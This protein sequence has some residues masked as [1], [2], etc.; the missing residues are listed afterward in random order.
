MLFRSDFEKLLSTTGSNIEKA[1]GVLYGDGATETAT[2]V[3]DALGYDDAKGGASIKGMRGC[4]VFHSVSGNNIFFPIGKSG[5][6]R[7]KSGRGK[8]DAVG[9]EGSGEANMDGVL[10]YAQRHA[11]FKERKE[12]TLA[13]GKDYNGGVEYMP[14]F[15]DLFKRYGAVYW[16]ERPGGPGA[17][18]GDRTQGHTAWDINYFTMGFE[19]FENGA[20]GALNGIKVFDQS[21][22]C[23]MRVV[24]T[25]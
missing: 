11:V 18:S 21:D 10:R 8:T 23:L 12:Y 7:R 5:H 9:D 2:A 14:M 16:L 3:A 13:L 1:Y 25:K 22:A 24:Y 6:G 17:V 19:G 4:F 20:I 15:Y